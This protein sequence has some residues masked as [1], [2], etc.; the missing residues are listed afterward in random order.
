MNKE[1]NKRQYKCGRAY[2]SFARFAVDENVVMP[3]F[4]TH[5]LAVSAR[6][7]AHAL[8][9][10]KGWKFKTKIRETDAGLFELSVCRVI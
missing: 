10:T 8:A 7:A 4:E 9:Y 1:G 3:A 5:A 2:Y 6:S